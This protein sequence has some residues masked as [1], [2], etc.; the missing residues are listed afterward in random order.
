MRS[1]H[2]ALLEPLVRHDDVSPSNRH[3]SRAFLDIP[4]RTVM[5]EKVIVPFTAPA[6][7]QKGS[8]SSMKGETASSAGCAT[9]FAPCKGHR[10]PRDGAIV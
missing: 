9:H 2:H 1:S 4:S 6:V 10:S 3:R 7:E 5:G 8:N